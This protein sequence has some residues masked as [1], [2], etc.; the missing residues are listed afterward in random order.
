[1]KER[2]EHFPRDWFTVKPD[3]PHLCACGHHLLDMCPEIVALSRIVSDHSADTWRIAIPDEDV[4]NA[5]VTPT[6]CYNP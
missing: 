1:M 6:I 5:T 2:P 4:E 3:D